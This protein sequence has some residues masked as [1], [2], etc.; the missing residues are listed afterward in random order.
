MAGV[1][2]V[3][4]YGVWCVPVCVCVCVVEEEAVV[5]MLP[6][7][8][9]VWGRPAAV[10]GSA[11][12]AAAAG[13]A[14]AAAHQPLVYCYGPADL[15]LPAAASLTYH[16]QLLQQQQHQQQVV[17]AAKGLQ[18]QQQPA[19]ATQ[20]VYVQTALGLQACRIPAAAAAAS[21]LTAAALPLPGTLALSTNNLPAGA[22]LSPDQLYLPTPAAAAGAATS[23]ALTSNRKV[24]PFL[25]SHSA[26]V[27]YRLLLDSTTFVPSD[28]I[29][30]V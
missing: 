6:V 7:S 12:M 11:V 25:P 28:D 3:Q 13:T 8:G 26:T 29:L 30:S 4:M 14:G 18:K 20:H 19:A 17:L 1:K 23:V 9:L 24:R 10:D 22:Y 2:E 27:S 15:Q 16:Q 21:P 5:A